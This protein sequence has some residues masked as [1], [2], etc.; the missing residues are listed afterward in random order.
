M[1]RKY[2]FNSL[3]SL[4]SASF[5][6]LMLIIAGAAFDNA[7]AQQPR[8]GISLE[9]RAAAAPPPPVGKPYMD[10]IEFQNIIKQADELLKTGS[11][12][13][14][15]ALLSPYEV[16]IFGPLEHWNNMAR[17]DWRLAQ[18]YAMKGD[19]NTMVFYLKCITDSAKQPKP[20]TH[21]SQYVAIVNAEGV[22]TGDYYY[23]AAL[24]S[25]DYDT[26]NAAQAKLD[27]LMQSFKKIKARTDP[28]MRYEYYPGSR[29]R[30]FR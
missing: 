22:E 12:N 28:R 23:G 5:L 30:R 18:A 27:L 25:Y 1:Y 16:Y 9:G 29:A 19:V 14:T 8:G 13:Q 24:N 26:R 3:F 17:Y 7:Y 15:L 21:K 2:L 4:S 20:L 10:D 6:A 11:F